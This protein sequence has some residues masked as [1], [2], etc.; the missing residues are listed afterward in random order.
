[1]PSSSSTDQAHRRLSHGGRAEL[2]GAV[3][4]AV[5]RLSLH[6]GSRSA[7]TGAVLPFILAPAGFLVAQF[8][9]FPT[10]PPSWWTDSRSASR[11]S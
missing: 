7:F 10:Y 4:R 2:V 9:N 8:V 5:P 11:S 1:M 3:E 6:A